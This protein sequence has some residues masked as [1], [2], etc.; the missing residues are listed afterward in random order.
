M[1]RYNEIRTA[2][3][4]ALVENADLIYR[5]SLTWSRSGVLA[6]TPT[7]C[8]IKDPRRLDYA[9]ARSL[10]LAAARVGVPFADLRVVTV[11]PDDARPRPGSRVAW[12][13]GTLELKEWSQSS[14]FTG[15][16]LGL[17]VIVR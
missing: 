11:H 8:S 4:S 15:S 13:G 17:A 9:S 3:R 2:A 7:R 10:E 14:D 1:T 16:S 6:P 5:H 12:D